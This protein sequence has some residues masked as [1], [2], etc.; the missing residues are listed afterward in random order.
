MAVAYKFEYINNTYV[1]FFILQQYIGIHTTEYIKLSSPIVP[2][3]T[4]VCGLH[5]DYNNE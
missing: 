3:T 5:I 4:V 2:S 1:L